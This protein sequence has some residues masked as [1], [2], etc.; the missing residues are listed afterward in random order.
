M[1]KSGFSTPQILI[2]VAALSLVGGVGL[3][4]L[5]EKNI[6][7][8]IPEKDVISQKLPYEG[9][10]VHSPASPVKLGLTW[11]KPDFLP[12]G[13]L[14]WNE[15]VF[16]VLESFLKNLDEEKSI[17]ELI[18]Q[19]VGVFANGGLISVEIPQ[20]FAFRQ[21]IAYP[22][23]NTCD[24]KNLPFFDGVIDKN[25][26]IYILG[27]GCLSVDAD[28]KIFS[29]N[30]MTWNSSYFV[31][32]KPEDPLVKEKK[33]DEEI[34]GKIALI[35]TIGETLYDGSYNNLEDIEESTIFSSIQNIQIRDIAVRINELGGR[36]VVRKN[37]A[38]SSFVVYSRLNIKNLEDSKTQYFCRS[39][40]GG[41]TITTQ[42]MDKA[43]SC[44]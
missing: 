25:Q 44:P 7:S 1:N 31:D 18:G 4:I 37:P 5:K 36:L 23:Y 30:G 12:K 43:I 8:E 33:L 32:K 13:L 42:N 20:G 16:S 39:N 41:T 29:G 9:L 19:Y 26:F 2:F 35:L 6:Y 10:I 40:F 38:G 11:N 34:M 14:N 17:K 3:R 27:A 24:K 28:Y 21:L 15:F 22:A